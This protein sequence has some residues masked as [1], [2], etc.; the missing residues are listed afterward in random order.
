M[1]SER[2]KID[3]DGFSEFIRRHFVVVEGI[4]FALYVMLKLRFVVV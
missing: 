4:L 3:L 1:Y 2:L